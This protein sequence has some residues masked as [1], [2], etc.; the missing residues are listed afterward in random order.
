[1][2]NT[3]LYVLLTKAYAGQ[4]SEVKLTHLSVLSSRYH[5]V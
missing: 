1:M 2:Q 5:I 4:L 3:E